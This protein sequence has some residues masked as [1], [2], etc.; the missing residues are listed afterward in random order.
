MRRAPRTKRPNGFSLLELL[1]A[2]V[3]FMILCG[4]AFGL[5]TVSQNAYQAESQILT[6][7]QEARF[8][9]D[10]IVR[11][12]D[13]AGYPP[14]NQFSFINPPPVN[15]YA[16]TPIAWSPGY[17]AAPC[18]VGGG[19]CTTPSGFDLIVETDIDPQ[20]NNGVEWV[21]YQLQGTTLMRGVASKTGNNPD[22]ATV[23]QLVPFVQNVMNNASAARIAQFQALSPAMYPGGQPVPIFNYMCDSPTSGQGPQPCSLAGVNNVPAAIRDVEITLIVVTPTPDPRTGQPRLVELNGRGYRVNPNQ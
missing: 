12:V 4:A 5:L 1:I 13:D 21:R 6:S 10:Q 16:S 9:L 14:Q 3:I 19:G 22:A 23:A 20:N 7:F 8:G 11:D 2:G 17:P 18:N 15:S